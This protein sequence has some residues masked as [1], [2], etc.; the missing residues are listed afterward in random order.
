MNGE[1]MKIETLMNIPFPC[2]MT[3]DGQVIVLAN[4]SLKKLSGGETESRHI[5]QVFDVWEELGGGKLIQA[6]CGNTSCIFIKTSI[7]DSADCLYIGTIST[8]LVSLIDELKES[9]RINRELDAIIDNSYDGIYITDKDGVTLRTNRAIERITGIPKEYYTGKNVNALIERGILENSVTHKVME[10]RRSVSV[11]Q[12][13]RTGKE[14]LLTGNPVF[15]DK[16]E[17]ES[18]VTNIRDLSELNDLQNAL[19]KATKLNDSYKK[20][21]ERLKS[22]NSSIS[23][24]IIESEELAAIYETADRIVNV[25]ATVLIL[26]ETGV[27]KDVLARYIYSRSG[28]SDKGRFIKVNCGAIPADLLESE[29]FGYEGGA[30]TGANKHGKPGMFELADGGVLFLDEVGELP[31]NLQVKLLRVIQEKE[32]QRVGA[33]VSKKADVRILAATN[34]DLKEMVQ[35]GE[36]REDLFYRLNVVPIFI[37]PLRNR[38]NDILP[39]VSFFLEKANLKYGKSKRMDAALKDFFYT[40]SWPG[41]VR[42]LANLV[43]RLVLISEEDVLTYENLPA[44]YNGEGPIKLSEIVTLK[45]A[46]EL[47]EEK[48]LTLAVQKYR[49]TYEIAEALDSSQPTIVRKLKKYGL[50][51]KQPVH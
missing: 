38:K 46:A 34:K 43:E 32:I 39:I 26:G 16:G 17:I 21:I 8:E 7:Q 45:E 23:D 50:A 49:T 9:K 44:E 10:K 24:V 20:E 33:T 6:A 2:M 14:T 11:V 19:R 37:P 18:I 29:L 4:A 48:I 47:A 40:Y 22:K 28:R 27:G 41:N 12:L 1:D 31:L 51:V 25:E 30:F 13:N 5:N 36:F 35:N 3:T 15:N 42:E